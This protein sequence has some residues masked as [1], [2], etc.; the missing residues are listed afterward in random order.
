METKTNTYRGPGKAGNEKR[1][2]DRRKIVTYF[3][4]IKTDMDLMRTILEQKKIESK[5]A[6]KL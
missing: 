1:A 2:G 6:R 3:G 5:R 4:H